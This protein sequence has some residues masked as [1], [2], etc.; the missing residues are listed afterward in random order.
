MPKMNTDRSV[1]MEANISK[2]TPHKAVYQQAAA[3]Q[4][5]GDESER[6]FGEVLPT[7]Y[8]STENL[9]EASGAVPSEVLITVAVPDDAAPLTDE[10]IAK[11]R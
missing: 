11:L 1:V 3:T 2:F 9:A 6:V 4:F 7:A 10:D 5:E 8:I